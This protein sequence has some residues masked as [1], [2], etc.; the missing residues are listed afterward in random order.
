[1][2][3]YEPAFIREHAD[4]LYSQA[5]STTA[6]W[7]IAGIIVGIMAGG[8]LGILL[9]VM[10]Q[11]VAAPATITP[12]FAVLAGLI[13]YKLGKDI[14]LDLKLKAQTA[15]CQLRT[16]ENTRRVETVPQMIAQARLQSGA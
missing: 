16:E 5:K 3:Q 2:T 12:L 4:R 11:K 13:G 14:A 6:I 7:T 10:M 1:M 15:L 8:M 9:F